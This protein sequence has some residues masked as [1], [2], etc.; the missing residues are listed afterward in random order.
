MLSLLTAVGVAVLVADLAV[1][2][3]AQ[4]VAW[5]KGAEATVVSDVKK[6]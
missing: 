1:R 6:L 2:R 3:G 5:L 4:V